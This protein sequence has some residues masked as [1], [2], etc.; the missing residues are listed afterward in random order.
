MDLSHLIAADSVLRLRYP[1][2]YSFLVYHHSELVFARYYGGQH[3]GDLMNLMSVAKSFTGALVGIALQEGYL[4]SLDQTLADFFPECR[5]PLAGQTALRQLLMMR[6]GLYWAPT[7]RGSSPFFRRMERTGDWVR[8]LLDLP[9]DPARPF[10]YKEADA[11]LLSA[12][13]TRATGM[14]ALAFADRYLFGPLGIS[15]RL[16]RTDPQGHNTGSGWLHLTA[17]DAAKLG[18]LYLQ[19]GRWGD[20]QVL[21][22]DWVRQSTTG[23]EYGYL[24][25]L[26]PAAG[27]RAYKAE[28]FG[29]QLIQVV[30]S[31]GLA[32]VITS[33]AEHYRPRAPSYILGDYVIPAV[34][35]HP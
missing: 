7:V 26:T 16:W 17:P 32:V 27:R 33:D 21:S 2:T 3:A 34:L 10:H 8:F 6:S 15:E 11:H 25:W 4:Q 29:G 19:E 9:V 24:W 35:S 23:D 20:T 1:G 22:P 30:P 13:I 14:P 18:L 12:V 28:G 31:L 5:N